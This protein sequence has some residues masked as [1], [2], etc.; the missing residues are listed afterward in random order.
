M[1]KSYIFII[2]FLG[3]MFMLQYFL[4]F[5]QMNSFKE[6]FRKFIK[7]GKVAI[8]IKKGG[9]KSGSIVMFGVD[10]NGTIRNA[11][12]INGITVFAR[13]K[14]NNDFNNIN[15][16]DIDKEVLT[17]TKFPK[18]LKQAILNA[19]DN[20]IRAERGEETPMEKSPFQKLSG[21]MKRG[22]A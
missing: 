22:A 21:L 3:A 2:L 15:I 11:A 5:L 16:K 18:S 14:E 20:Y 1:E 4:T 13:F 9:F 10:E 6:Y 12:F 8:G 17:G 7:E 19:K